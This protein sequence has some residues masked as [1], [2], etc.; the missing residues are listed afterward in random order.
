MSL[1]KK[2]QR[3]YL[4]RKF[5]LEISTQ[6]DCSIT[7]E[8][9]ESIFYKGNV[10]SMKE[11]VCITRILVKHFLDVEHPLYA[12]GSKRLRRHNRMDVFKRRH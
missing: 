12:L 9:R 4:N 3:K 5:L 8:V 2:Y 1:L 11:F 6:V 10:L 7:R